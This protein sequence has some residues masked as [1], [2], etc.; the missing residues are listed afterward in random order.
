M[1]WRPRA[2]SGDQLVPFTYYCC[3]MHAGWLSG[4]RALGEIGRWIFVQQPLAAI[5]LFHGV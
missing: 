1:R 5:T 3:T 2:G 4:R